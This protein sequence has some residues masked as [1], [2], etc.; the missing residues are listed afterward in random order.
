MTFHQVS[1]AVW[2]DPLL[3]LKQ[4]FCGTWTFGIGGSTL[5]ALRAAINLE[6]SCTP[7]PS[8][9]RSLERAAG[10]ADL[11]REK[12]SFSRLRA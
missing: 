4:Y 5:A 7:G 9:T 2:V 3:L 12:L 11:S 1:V 10:C 8:S 6:K